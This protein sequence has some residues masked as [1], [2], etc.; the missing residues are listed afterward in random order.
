[1]IRLHWQM[2]KFWIICICM[3]FNNMIL[4]KICQAKL[5]RG[6]PNL[7]QLV[8]HYRVVSRGPSN[9]HMMI[10]MVLVHLEKGRHVKVHRSL[11]L[12]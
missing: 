10:V 2:R 8:V 5:P 1:M 7:I 12:L 3:T 4:T 11:T 6:K 9:R